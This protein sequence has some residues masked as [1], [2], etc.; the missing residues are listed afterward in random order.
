[1]SAVQEEELRDLLV[2]LAD[3][4]RSVFSVVFKRLWTPIYRFCVSMLGNDADAS[5]AAQE[6][7]AKVLARASEYDA[8]RPPVPWAL[9]IAAW[10]CRTLR[11]KRFRRRET[12]EDE[13]LE[14]FTDNTEGDLLRRDMTRA[15]LTAMTELSELDQETLL[16]S[17][18]EESATASGATFRKRRERALDRLRTAFRRLYGFD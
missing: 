8:A 16:A 9:A 13:T 1:M 4:E 10:E 2:R 5:D 14:P 6:A 15:A 11:R 18:L 7:L 17:F 12:P 3:G